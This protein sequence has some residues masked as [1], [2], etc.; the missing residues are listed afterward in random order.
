MI[1]LLNNNKDILK[2]RENDPQLDETSS[3]EDVFNEEGAYA[4]QK[5]QE[6]GEIKEKK[7]NL[8]QYKD[9]EGLTINKLNIGLWLVKNRRNI[10]L[11]F[12]AFLIMVSFIAWSI[13]FLNFGIYIASGMHKEQEI[14]NYLV[15]E[16][17][18]GGSY[19]FNK[20]AKE[21]KIGDIEA[22]KTLDSNYDIYTNVENT[23]QN[24]S[25]EFDYFFMV[26]NQKLETAS[27]FVLP[28]QSRY[29]FTLNTALSGR[30][31]NITFNIENLKWT[32]IDPHVYPDWEDFRNKRLAID[33]SGIE[34]IPSSANKITE[35]LDLNNLKFDVFNNT[36]F[37]YREVDFSI[38]LYSGG[39]IVGVGNYV[40]D[41]L[42][43]EQEQS[44]DI[45]WPGALNRV[46]DIVIYPEVNILD[47]DVYLK[48]DGGT[49]EK[50]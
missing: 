48:F 18:V 35:K 2:T 32:R 12:H 6:V 28:G 42:M 5:E 34:F 37:N 4:N 9:P 13:F 24:H 19:F 27:A 8:S 15:S 21:L 30:P 36:A 17:L 14:I 11:L 38:L 1:D 44:V 47:E 7:Y 39:K 25:L 16:N 33:V 41:K 45:V 20:S 46:N 31:Q 26:G 23:N 29:L 50:K 40:M 49:G 22:I 3:T 10:F 43:S